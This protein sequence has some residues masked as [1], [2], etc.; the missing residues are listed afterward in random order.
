MIHR[1]IVQIYFRARRGLKNSLQRYNSIH[2]LINSEP[3]IS[4]NRRL[5]VTTVRFPRIL[6]C[7]SS[8]LR[9]RR[10][11]DN[12]EKQL[13]RVRP[14]GRVIQQHT[15]RGRDFPRQ[16]PSAAN[17]FGMN[18][19]HWRT[20]PLCSCPLP[21]APKRLFQDLPRQIG[22]GVGHVPPNGEGAA[23]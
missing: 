14:P 1:C 8:F 16:F 11:G 23:D 20:R 18:I 5:V 17:N 10:I 22:G 2:V 3:V 6:P 19:P 21:V 15:G 13:F 12:S 9:Y 4:W 7:A